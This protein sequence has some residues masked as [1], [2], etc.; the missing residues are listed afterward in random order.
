[1][2]IGA[3][4]D[5]ADCLFANR[6]AQSQKELFDT[7][8]CVAERFAKACATKANALL[9][10]KPA[11]GDVIAWKVNTLNGFKKCLI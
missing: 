11:A 8:D 10:M 2:E 1:M 7:A 5:V 6:T 9:A 3:A 4:V